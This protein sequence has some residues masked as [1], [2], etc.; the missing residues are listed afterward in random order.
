[1]SVQPAK[2]EA[3]AFGDIVGWS[4]DSLTEAFRAFQA[5]ARQMVETPFPTKSL[6]INGIRLK[7]VA[8]IALTSGQLDQK[9]ARS[10]FEQHFTP[11]R[12]V[13]GQNGF[14]TG[15]FEPVVEAARKPDATYR[16]PLYRRPDD[17]IDLRD[18]NRPSHMDPSYRFGRKTDEGI[19]Y[20]FDRAAIDSG[21]LDDQGLEIAWLADRVDQFFVHVQGSAW[22]RFRDDQMM[23]VT[24]AAKAGHPYTSLGK[25]LCQR[26]GVPPAEMTADRLADWMRANPDELDEV[27]AN[28]R[29]Y[30]F[31]REVEQNKEEGPIG[32]ADCPLIAGRSLAIDRTAHT[33]GTPV[34]ISSHAPFVDSG[35]PLRRLMIAHDTGSA[36]VGPAR[37]DIFIGSGA[38]AGLLAGKVRHEIDMIVFV[39]RED[40]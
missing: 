14:L 30:I 34:W 18:H 8:D 29:S 4:E 10:F 16:Y 39:P 31:F 28:N 17:L 26:L 19:D 21:A 3:V 15:Y 40:R 1:M 12:I 13:S 22:L 7:E 27:L 35:Q 38:Q 6:G 25:L 23:R 33:F 2:L 24:Y 9:K 32:A 20:F 36:I 11:H 5:S 37:G